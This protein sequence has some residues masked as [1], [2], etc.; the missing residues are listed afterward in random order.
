LASPTYPQLWQRQAALLLLSGDAEGYRR[1]CARFVERFGRTT[2]VS[3]GFAVAYAC[4]L[5]PDP[6][7]DNAVPLRL[8][9]QAL[10]AAPKATGEQFEAALAYHRAG[11]PGQAIKALNGSPQLLQQPRAWA[12][13]ALAHHQL[14]QADDARRWLAKADEWYDR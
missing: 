8:A 3:T 6:A 2:V 10:K 12:A 7:R 14:G 1:H 13:L 4:N 5:G 9:Q 11:Q